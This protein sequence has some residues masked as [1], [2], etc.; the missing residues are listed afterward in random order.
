M[1]MLPRLGREG[2]A[3]LD[4]PLELVLGVPGIGAPSGLP[5]ALAPLEQG[6]L[7]PLGSE[8]SA[9]DV[10]V[11]VPIYNAAEHVER[12]LASLI[13]HTRGGAHLVLIDDSSTEPEI[14]A[15]LE[16]HAHISGITVLRNPRNLGFTATANRG[17]AAAGRADV[18]LLNADTVVGPNWL[19]GLRRAAYACADTGTATAVSDN[20]G[21]FSV[22]E[23][24]QANELP[25]CW[26]IS[27]AARGLWQH[28][29]VAYPKLPTG[30]GF[31][32]YI[33]RAMLDA[34]GAFDEVAFPRG[35]GEENDLC[36]RARA[37]GWHHVIAGNVLVAH[38]RSQSFGESQR[39]ALGQAGMA[40]LRDRY[41]D[42]EA[43]VAATLYSFERLVL[44]W[45][46]RRIFADARSDNVPLPRL[47]WTGNAAPAATDWEIWLVRHEGNAL[48]LQ[49]PTP[50]GTK[51]S[52]TRVASGVET[53]G[54]QANA[55]WDWL[56]LWAIECVAI[57]SDDEFGLG[58]MARALDIPTFC[59]QGP[60]ANAPAYADF[61]A[62]SRSFRRI[63]P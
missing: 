55:L 62:K 15:L 42:Y 33:K 27:A 56:Q 63:S 48:V 13:E 39:R 40:M 36:Q 18:V 53:R 2:P 5:N 41:P 35:Y 7:V 20:A 59:L 50:P 17:L 30:N 21:A 47:L 51:P 43:Q 60:G 24:E 45:R 23:L 9:P 6:C 46:V 1:R 26:T 37:G 31:C 58:P 25:D 19:C 61:A 32:M 8:C 57:H 22:P 44:D 29:G 54:S 28:A 38:A 16:R 3:T 11:A 4:A 12:C 34:V 49:G 10:V 14:A 52:M